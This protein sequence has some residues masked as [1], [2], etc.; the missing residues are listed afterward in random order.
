MAQVQR[1]PLIML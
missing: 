1:A